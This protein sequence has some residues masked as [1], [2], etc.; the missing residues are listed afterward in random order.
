MLCNPINY[1]FSWLVSVPG[2]ARPAGNGRSPCQGAQRRLGALTSQ[3]EGRLHGATQP[4]CRACQGLRPLPAHGA[5][6]CS[7]MEALNPQFIGLQSTR[8]R[9]LLKLGMPLRA[10]IAVGLSRKGPWHL[11]RTLVTNGGMNNEW[12]KS[13]GLIS[14]KELWVNIHYPA[15]AR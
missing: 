2:K 12:L 8:V 5:L 11:A 14:I 13:Q 15:T 7:T 3:P 9:N 6:L 1:G 4:C 10:A